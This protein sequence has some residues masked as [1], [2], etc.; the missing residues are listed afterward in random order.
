V[1]LFKQENL[2]SCKTRQEFELAVKHIAL[3]RV[4]NI[5]YPCRCS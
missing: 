3:N 4:P 2:F 1:Y 5:I